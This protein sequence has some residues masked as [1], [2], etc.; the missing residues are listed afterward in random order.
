[1][2]SAKLSQ[3][4]EQVIGKLP[5]KNQDWFDCSEA[6]IQKLAS[7]HKRALRRPG[8]DQRSLHIQFKTKVR[9]LKDLWWSNKVAELQHLADSSQTCRFFEGIQAVFGPRTRKIAPL[10]SRNRDDRL[11]EQGQVFSRWAE[12]FSEVLNPTNIQTDLPYIQTLEDRPV[13]EKLAD[14]PTHEEFITAIKKLKNVKTPVGI[15]EFIEDYVLI[16]YSFDVML[17]RIIRLPKN[18]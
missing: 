15:Y 10:Y 13:E 18:N 2:Y 9:E 11:T 17:Q 14:S 12:H 5:K 7:E 4:A 1:M 16:I 3:C 8:A 6:E